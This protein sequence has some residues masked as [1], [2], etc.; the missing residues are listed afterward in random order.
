MTSYLQTTRIL[1][2]CV[3]AVSVVVLLMYGMAADKFELVILV[4]GT[5][6]IGGLATFFATLIFGTRAYSRGSIESF[7]S[8][9]IFLLLLVGFMFVGGAAALRILVGVAGAA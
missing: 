3:A 1:A 4:A 8:W 9:G 5:G 7:L 2:L 6:L